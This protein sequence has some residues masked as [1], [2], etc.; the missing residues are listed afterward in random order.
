LD[1]IRRLVDD[2][3]V[4]IAVNRPTDEGVP[5][6]AV[7][8]EMDPVSVLIEGRDEHLKLAT[9]LRCRPPARVARRCRCESKWYLIG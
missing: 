5:V 9:E 3:R 1:L 7:D 8:P 4:A 6:I 2:A